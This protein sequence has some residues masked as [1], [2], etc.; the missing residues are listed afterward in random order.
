MLTCKKLAKLLASHVNGANMTLYNDLGI[1]PDATTTEVKAAYRSRAQSTHPDKDGGSAEA[2]HKVKQAYKILSNE[3]KRENYD[4]HGTMDTN[5]M[6]L[7]DEAVAELANL[8]MQLVNKVVD[9]KFIN[10][11]DNMQD[12]VKNQLQQID[13]AKVSI[14]KIIERNKQIAD[15]LTSKDGSN[16]LFAAMLHANSK[17]QALQGK[18]LKK[19]IAV[20]EEMLRVLA[21]YKYQVDIKPTADMFANNPFF[22]TPSIFRTTI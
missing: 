17:E 12:A 4:K 19:A 8:F 14:G 1:T 16:N 22:A 6:T 20:Y 15:R 21:E 2:F 11:I 13:A 3:T 9:F 10:L 18:K 7:R 5:E